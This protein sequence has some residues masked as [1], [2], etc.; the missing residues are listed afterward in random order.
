M[1]VF[2]GSNF[3]LVSMLERP[4]LHQ[5]KKKMS[6]HGTGLF[7]TVFEFPFMTAAF[8]TSINAPKSLLN[9]YWP[10]N[11]CTFMD[12]IFLSC[13]N[14]FVVSKRLLV[15]EV[16]RCWKLESWLWLPANIDPILVE[17][18]PPP[19]LPIAVSAHTC[20]G[21]PRKTSEASMNRFLCM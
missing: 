11:I 8:N 4:I 16:F 20:K 13:I 17:E 5:K 10:L 7:S 3:P 9:S 6:V 21:L 1:N 18:S 19:L 2:K 12:H 15:C 14:A